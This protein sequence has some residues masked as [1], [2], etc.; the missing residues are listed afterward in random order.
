MRIQTTPFLKRGAHLLGCSQ[1]SNTPCAHGQASPRLQVPCTRRGATQSTVKPHACAPRPALRLPGRQHPAAAQHARASRRG[2]RQTRLGG[3]VQQS[4]V[5]GAHAPCGSPG[6]AGR[7]SG[8]SP[9]SAAAPS[10]HGARTG[11]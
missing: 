9:D 4:A 3:K 11:R 6:T 8:T 1:H 5:R 7:C 10:R 2:A